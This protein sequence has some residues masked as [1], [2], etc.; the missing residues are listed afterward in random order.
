MPTRPRPCFSAQFVLHDRTELWASI[1]G[2]WL[3]KIGVRVESLTQ[4]QTYPTLKKSE[5]AKSSQMANS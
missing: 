4:N 5:S 2:K 3:L 1:F